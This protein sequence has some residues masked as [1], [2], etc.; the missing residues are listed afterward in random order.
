MSNKS[1]IQALIQKQRWQEAQEKCA[2]FCNANPNDAEA[3]F[4]LGAI[5]GQVGAFAESE[6]ACSRSLALRPDMPI[7]LCNLGIAFRQQGKLEEALSVLR[8]AIKLKPDFAQA[9]NELGGALQ[10]AGQ[11]D[12]AAENYRLAMSLNP[13]YA[14]ACFNLATVF[15]AQGKIA[16]AIVTL[17][18]AIKLQP[19]Y[20]EAHTL[21]GRLLRA[22][23]RLDEAIVYF[24]Q[25]VKLKPGDAYAWNALGGAVMDSLSHRSFEEAEKCY[26][27]A[28]RYQPKIPEFYVNLAM[29]LR[30]PGRHEEALDLFRKAV[31]LRPGYET[32]I[33]GAAEVLEH[34]GEF[35]DAYATIRPLLEQGTTESAVALAYAAMAHH[36]DQRDAALALLEKTVLLPKPAHELRA[37]HFALGKLHESMKAYDKSFRHFA[38][39]HRI[40][41]ATFDPAQNRRTFDDLIEVFSAE[42]LACLPRSSSRS[43]LPVF[44]VGMPRSGTSL[45][46]QILASHPQVYGAG[47]LEDIHRMT[48]V[49]SNMLGGKTAYPQCVASVKRRHLDELAQRHLAMLG[50]FTKTATRVTDKMPHNF[51]TLGLIELLFP[52]A[53]IIHCKRDPIDTCLSIY[54]L[55]FTANHPYADSLEH[56]GS[57][58][59]EYLRLMEHWKTV[60]SVP[61]LEVQYEELVA[62]QERISRQMVEFCGLPWD[63]RCLNFH[64]AERLVTTHSYDQVRRP[65]YKQ[66]VARWKHY[67]R[68]LAP[69]IEALGI[70]QRAILVR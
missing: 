22:E 55:E 8:Q 31:E 10:L 37:L 2:Q 36:I 20:V 33:G 68:H 41:P 40:E 7:T 38:L 16:D 43:K 58:Y 47:E 34:K 61:V 19:E 9:Y 70:N 27:E 6:A 29:L 69:L 60:L 49:L 15:A 28:I 17:Q 23:K 44:I 54:G 53:R 67:E 63:E 46:E 42:N 57:Y 48:V 14:L 4:L 13:A 39:A 45:V 18:Q 5:Y 30:V 32:A 66:S 52:S 12:N 50:K 65:I 56:L 26:R 59:L 11:L 3:W 35:D 64:E 51:M 25:A 24:R 21:V 1:Q 62:D